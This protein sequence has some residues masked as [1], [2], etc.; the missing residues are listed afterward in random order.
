MRTHLVLVC[1]L[2]A[3][4]QAGDSVRRYGRGTPG[5]GNIEPTIWV[6][7]APRPGDAGFEIR[8]ERVLGGTWAF[9]FLGTVPAD[10]SFSGV[11]FLVDPR[12]AVYGG[13]YFMAGQ[14]NGGGAGSIPLPLPAEPGLV[15]QAVYVQA[16]TLDDFAPNPLGIGATTGLRLVPAGPAALLTARATRGAPD[17]QAVIDLAANRVVTFDATRFTEARGAAFVQH[18]NVA[19]AADPATARLHVFDASVAPPA[20]VSATPLSAD[21]VADAIVPS[22]DGTRAYVLHVGVVGT[23]PPL[24]AYDVRK[25]VSLGQPW[26]GA[27]IRLAGVADARGM[28]FRSDSAEAFVASLGSASGTS[29]SVVRVDVDPSSPTFHQESARLAFPGH[30]V[31]DVAIAPDDSVLYVLLAAPG[32]RSQLAIVDRSTLVPVDQDPATPGV[33][34]LGGELS[35]PR[36]AIPDVVERLLAD[37]RGEEVYCSTLG[38]VVR[39]GVAPGSASPRQ[40]VF[41]GDNISAAEVV[42]AM[43]LGDAGERLYAATL[44]QV[45]EIDTSTGLSPRGWPLQDVV[46]LA[47][48]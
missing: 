45:V 25:G 41:I 6:N 39:V 18:G 3:V 44:T 31:R 15:G 24:A 43:V 7:R 38:G 37:P 47:F 10:V 12:F 9:P 23:Q 22:P 13:A 34:H 14:G 29:G 35:V 11:R 27:P 30:E 17:A 16:F 48:R 36:T 8:V 4:L 21:G 20:W 46:A 2:T 5:S 19:L 32:Q 26:P 1:T 33:Q 42:A 28:V 40:V